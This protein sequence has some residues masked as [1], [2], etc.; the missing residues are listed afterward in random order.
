MAKNTRNLFGKTG[1]DFVGTGGYVGAPASPTNTGNGWPRSN[2]AWLTKSGDAIYGMPGWKRSLPSS[3]AEATANEL[4][5]VKLADPNTAVEITQGAIVAVTDGVSGRVMAGGYSG[6]GINMRDQDTV[7]VGT[8][9]R[10]NNF[11]FPSLVNM[12]DKI[13]VIK[14]RDPGVVFDGSLCR[15]WGIRAPK[16]KPIVT[17]AI[18]GDTTTSVE[19]CTSGWASSQGGNVTV[20]HPSSSPVSPDGSAYLKLAMTDSITKAALAYKNITVTIPATAKS[21]TVWVYLDENN[22]ILPKEK[23]QLAVSTTAA[24]GGTPIAIDFPIDIPPKQWTKVTFPWEQSAPVNVASIGFILAHKLPG[25]VF[26]G[27]TCDLL[28]DQIEYIA[29]ANGFAVGGDYQFCFTW[30]DSKRLR[31]SNPSPFSE[32][33]ALQSGQGVTINASGHYAAIPSTGM[34]NLNPQLQ[35]VSFSDWEW[36]TAGGARWYLRSTNAARYPRLFYPPVS[37]WFNTTAFTSGTIGSLGAGEYAYGDNDSLGYDTLY[38]RMADDSDPN[39]AATHSIKVINPGVDAIKVYMT[40]Q[41]WGQDE[42]GQAIWRC[43]SDLYIG[44]ALT[45]QTSADNYAITVAFS[46]DV[47]EEEIYAGRG[48]NFYN[49]KPTAAKYAVQD[50]ERIAFCGQDDYLVGTVTVASDLQL[51]SPDNAVADEDDPIF[52]YWMEDRQI[53]FGTETE[54]YAI[55]QAFS[56][57]VLGNVDRLRIGKDFRLSVNGYTTVYQGTPASGKT[58]RIIGESNTVWFTA[59]TNLPKSGIGPWTEG[60]GV[61]NYIQLEMP[62]DQITGCGHIGD[63]LVIFGTKYVYLLVQDKT[64]YDDEGQPA[65]IQP[66]QMNGWP[67]SISHRGIVAVPGGVICYISPTNSIIAGSYEG[68]QEVGCSTNIFGWLTSDGNIE[69]EL[70]KY[71]LGFYHPA[72][73]LVIYGFPE[74]A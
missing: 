29:P 40:K 74:V 60:M 44:N 63:D 27:P 4:L 55:I 37:V 18:P 31:E 54:L 12:R 13:H 69:P 21:I 43:M 26:R 70:M 58:Y 35:S 23:M 1:E 34:V 62:G 46:D 67:G 49:A 66:R 22:R 2:N 71:A 53:R 3:L 45:V 20:T 73:K 42:R 38:I 59:K 36:V 48:L 32:V 61:A 24:L 52:G 14:E 6:S 68:F 8:M 5:H 51:V 10:M 19:P 30:W 25:N 11:D 15:S 7:M 17:P 28:F 47:S 72:Y 64:A 41:Q 16:L 57:T 50:G 65:Y 33:I 39:A 9:S 56:S